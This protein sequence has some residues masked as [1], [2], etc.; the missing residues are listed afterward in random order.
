MHVYIPKVRQS[1]LH[2]LKP[3]SST[4]T[5]ISLSPSSTFHDSHHLLGFANQ[6]RLPLRQEVTGAAVNRQSESIQ[7][8]LLVEK[9][10]NEVV[11]IAPL[12][13]NTP[14][15][16]SVHM[17][18]MHMS[19][20]RH[21][22]APSLGRCCRLLASTPLGTHATP[23]SCLRCARSSIPQLSTLLP[24]HLPSPS[25]LPPPS[26]ALT[27]TL[28]R[29]SHRSLPTPMTR[30]FPTP[31]PT[32]TPALV[33]VSCEPSRMHHRSTGTKKKGGW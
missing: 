14:S 12:D 10:D 16:T 26:V 9:N 27:P 31:S 1:T 15:L 3:F 20:A 13:E 29:T 7:S 32:S 28:L 21:S 24:R 25:A 30:S 22:V 11:V 33:I 8:G 4:S 17:S 18:I 23:S 5:C 6:F 2:D 19:N